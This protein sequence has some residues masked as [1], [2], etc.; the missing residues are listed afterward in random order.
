MCVGIFK[1]QHTA[2]HMAGCEWLH[3]P[4]RVRISMR[5]RYDDDDDDD[6]CVKVCASADGALLGVCVNCSLPFAS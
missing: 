4:V 1:A 2:Q 3:K 5:A 6:S